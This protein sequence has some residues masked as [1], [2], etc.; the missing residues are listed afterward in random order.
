MPWNIVLSL[1]LI[2]VAML[3]KQERFPRLLVYFGD[4]S[5]S[6]YLIHFFVIGVA[7]RLLID[8]TVINVKN[9]IV[10]IFAIIM[11]VMSSAICYEVFEKRVTKYLRGFIFKG[12]KVIE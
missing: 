7:A 11:A 2:I 5:Y 1:A 6:M 10:I 12:A 8:N 4:M 9:T 3:F